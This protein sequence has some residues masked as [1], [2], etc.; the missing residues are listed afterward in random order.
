MEDP[1]AS[2]IELNKHKKLSFIQLSIIIFT[3]TCS[4]PFG[5][6]E[7]I[8]SGGV[9]YTLIGLI[10]LPFVYSIPQSL[11]CAE[12]GSMMPSHHGYII[13]VF[14]GF[15]NDKYGHFL[16]FY[17]AFGCIIGMA[18]DIPIYPILM[19]FYFKKLIFNDFNF[20]FSWIEEYLLYL[21][22]ILIG[23]LFNIANITTLGNS[24]I[25]FT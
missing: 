3:L 13:W 23:A 1:Y 22:L 19:L 14:R 12:L 8:Q 21:L 18:K 24:T 2:N 11:M 15:E 7:A 16:G 25:L 4:G 6:E 5:I 20:E 9:L 17:N 10:I